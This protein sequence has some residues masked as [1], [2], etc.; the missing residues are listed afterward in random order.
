MV[1]KNFN[2]ALSEIFRHEGGYVDNKSDPGGATNMGIT[3]KTLAAW[4]GIKPYNKLPKSEVKNLK[5]SEAK[6][7]YKA[8]Y[9]D[10]IKAD[11]LPDGL[12][13]ALFDFA[14]NS[15][16]SRAAKTLQALL[17]VKRDGII[18]PITLQALKE[19]IAKIGIGEIIKQICALRLKFLRRLKNYSI[20][21]KGWQRRVSNIEKTSLT[22]AQN[23]PTKI[24]TI[25]PKKENKIMNFLSGYK[26]YIMGVLMIVAALAQMAGADLPGFDNQSSVELILQALAFIFLRR[27]IKSGFAK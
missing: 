1:A 13:L 2:F 26:T 25:K 10:R 12:D 18:G 16:V 9:W 20:F 4:R 3:R 14:V 8:L 21:G 23:S 7:I 22:L 27:G 11:L 17:K 5:K 15:G 24:V 19:Q 6:A